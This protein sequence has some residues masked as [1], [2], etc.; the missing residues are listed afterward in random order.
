MSLPR[1]SGLVALAAAAL[2]IAAFAHWH[3]P[4]LKG[5][6]FR[7][8]FENSPPD[9]FIGPDN[10]PAGPA[11]QVVREAARRR[12]I[13]LEW[14]AMPSGPETAMARGAVDLWPIFGRLPDRVQRYFISKPWCLRRFWLVVVR[15]SGYRRFDQLAGKTIAVPYPG[16][17]ERAAQM[18][19]PRFRT[20]RVKSATD[21]LG[22]VCS[23]ASQG[24]LFW[25]RGGR[26]SVVDP[27][28]SCQGQELRYLNIPGA[29]VYSGVG[30]SLRNPDAKYAAMAI[31]EEISNLSR[32]GAISSA[33]FTWTNQST[34][35]TMVIDLMEA[36][37]NRSVLLSIA[38]ALLVA[39]IAYVAAQNRWL[40]ALRR[41]AD[42][43]C[44]Q[45]TRAASVKAE[46]LADMS[47]EIRT[48]MNGILG[49]CELLLDTPL[50]A[51]QAD[52]AR[53][54]FGSAHALLDIINGVLD[55]SKIESGRMQIASEPFDM[56]E[57]AASVIDV[58]AARARERKIELL[59]DLAPSARARFRGDA[60]RLR[61]VLLNL[62]GNAIKF[63]ARGHVLISIAADPPEAGRA[64]LRVAVEDTGIGIDRSAQGQLFEK[65]TQ[66]DAST[67]RKYGG[68]GL[69]L[70]ICRQLVEL[71]GGRIGVESQPGSGSRFHF[72]LPFELM[73]E[74]PAPAAPLVGLRVA[75]AS[76]G[77]PARRVLL[78]T[79]RQRG[80]QV[81]PFDERGPLPEGCDVVLADAGDWNAA[82]C[83]K[84]P[85]MI[86]ATIP[87]VL[88]SDSRLAPEKTGG[89]A[90]WLLKPLTPAR[91]VS[92]LLAACPPSPQPPGLE[93]APARAAA[94]SS[95]P[96]RFAGA[97]V[98][99]VEDNAVNQTL[100]RRMVERRGCQVEVAGDGAKAVCMALSAAYD[101]ILMDC[102]MPGMDGFEATRILRT[103]LGDRTPPVIAVTARA[104]EEDR[105]ECAAA[106]MSDYLA[107]PIG[108]ALVDEMLRKWLAAKA[109][110][111]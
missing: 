54:V 49:T 14:V 93:N 58:F 20:L 75:F 6:T 97:R 102:Q 67:T 15:N 103:N 61:Q 38:A 45:A 89:K 10:Q 16:M 71:M 51:E 47:H 53:V 42:R 88:L 21:V 12:G 39:I 68:T 106:G 50:N 37:R 19:E 2:A 8:G 74:Q 7:I 84:I 76:Q 11:I 111:V 24:G 65:F 92:A 48:P 101:L 1:K 13:R 70:A 91:L 94:A 30:A 9:Q 31:R 86:P 40:K 59:L 72:E 36:E 81:I 62:T 4:D 29:L 56:E 60:A 107:K 96:P 52:L 95:P 66:A 23:G 17:Q 85:A 28:P 87:A 104:M 108:S 57:A 46:F 79:L 3:A 18:F 27:P 26:S 110:N 34:N 63:T 99:I 22:A 33:Y 35:D 100:L 25:E 82:G 105:R 55:L 5:R 43:A 41:T 83:P 80:A 32:D 73:P 90:A 69:G 98:L 109:V 64:L 78:E 77:E 44:A